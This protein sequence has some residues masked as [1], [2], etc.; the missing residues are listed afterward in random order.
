MLVVIGAG[1]AGHDRDAR[2]DHVERQVG[3][4]A[5]FI[6]VGKE[7]VD[8]PG[9]LSEHLARAFRF[10]IERADEGQFV[11]LDVGFGDHVGEIGSE[12]E[13]RKELTEEGEV[14]PHFHF[15]AVQAGLCDIAEG[16]YRIRRLRVEG[17]LDRVGEILVEGAQR[18]H[19]ARLRV[20]L[21]AEVD[22]IDQGPLEVRVT[23]EEE[24]AVDVEGGKGRHLPEGRAGQRARIGQAQFHALGQIVVQVQRR[25]DVGFFEQVLLAV[26]EGEVHQ[27]DQSV[28]GLQADDGLFHAGADDCA[29]FPGQRQFDHAV[30]GR[31]VL[32][33]IV[34]VGRIE[35]VRD[36]HAFHVTR[37]RVLHKAAVGSL[38]Q[39]VVEEVGVRIAVLHEKDLIVEGVAVFAEFARTHHVSAAEL[40]G[41]ALSAPLLEG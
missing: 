25:Q 24:A 12:A 37:L 33:G 22:I 31:D 40:Q 4:R 1:A 15:C 17:T 41:G 11:G 38:D 18:D 3:L 19:F 29:Q 13:V 39:V 23:N 36:V 6:L 30:G 35:A 34:V 26:Q 20:E 2:A 14:F 32:L 7:A 21:P 27:G 5:A 28:E 8:H 9:S 10:G 16:Q